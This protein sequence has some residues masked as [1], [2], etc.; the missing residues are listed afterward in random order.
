MEI[1][2]EFNPI[3]DGLKKNGRD[4]LPEEENMIRIWMQSTSISPAFVRRAL[5]KY[6]GGESIKFAFRCETDAQY[7]LEYLLRC[8]K[9]HYYRPRFPALGITEND[10]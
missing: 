4:V 3:R 8:N 6:G 2:E 9:G 10:D 1:M 5:K 7:A